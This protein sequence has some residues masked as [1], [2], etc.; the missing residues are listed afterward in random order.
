MKILR[1]SFSLLVAFQIAGCEKQPKISQTEI[2]S[3]WVSLYKKTGCL[4]GGQHWGP[5]TSEG[6]VFKQKDWQSFFKLSPKLT[7]PFLMKRIDSTTETNVHVCPFHMATEGELAVYASEH[8]LN[9]NWFDS[10]SNYKVLA[11]WSEKK[12]NAS[13]PVTRM[14]LIDINAKNELKSYFL[15]DISGKG[16]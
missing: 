1:L 9:K 6:S 4:T 10:D 3:K 2:Q 13:S 16:F 8:I 14:M 15:S 5:G 7:I 12:K 11:V